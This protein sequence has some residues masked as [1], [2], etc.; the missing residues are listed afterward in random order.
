[1]WKVF[2]LILVGTDRIDTLRYDDNLG[3]ASLIG[4]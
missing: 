3:N 2:Q 4:G 1:M